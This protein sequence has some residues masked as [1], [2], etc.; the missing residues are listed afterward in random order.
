[1][2]GGEGSEISERLDA[3]ALSSDAAAAG[4][5]AVIAAAAEVSG[6]QVRALAFTQEEAGRRMDLLDGRLEAVVGR[7][8]A[9]EH[10]VSQVSE[11]VDAADRSASSSGAVAAEA[12]GAVALLEAQLLGGGGDG[13]EG[14]LIAQLRAEVQRTAEALAEV[15]R[16]EQRTAEALA[17]VQQQQQQLQEEPKQRS[18]APVAAAAGGGADAA[19]CGPSGCGWGICSGSGSSWSLCWGHS[20]GARA[21][22]RFRSSPGGG[23]FASRRG[24]RVSGRFL[25]SGDP[26]PA[27]APGAHTRRAQFRVR[28]SPLTSSPPSLPPLTERAGGGHRE[29][30]GERRFRVRAPA[31]PHVGGP[32]VCVCARARACARAHCDACV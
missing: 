25:L 14:G 15:Q 31:S 18:V 7:T 2:G 29:M 11:Q 4:A 13:G 23:A 16:G 32:K 22:G 5:A 8:E 30:R 21:A 12:A 10:G 27:L 28:A 24:R 26:Q 19:F 9:L 3:A 1:M 6:E 20:L 17:A